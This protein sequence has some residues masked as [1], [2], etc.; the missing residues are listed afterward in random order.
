M[1][2]Q[3]P[4]HVRDGSV[5]D[6][7]HPQAHFGPQSHSAPEINLRMPQIRYGT[8]PDVLWPLGLC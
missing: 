4:Q 6:L 8:I 2:I 7:G 5:A 1:G 3:R